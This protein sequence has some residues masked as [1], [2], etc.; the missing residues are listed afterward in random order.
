MSTQNAIVSGPKAKPE[1]SRRAANAGRISEIIID[2]LMTQEKIGDH[3]GV[4]QT[5]IA[6]MLVRGELTSCFEDKPRK[7]ERQRVTTTEAK[8]RVLNDLVYA[9]FVEDFEAVAALRQAIAMAD[10]E[11]TAKR[12][13]KEL[14]WRLDS[15]TTMFSALDAT[16][17]SRAAKELVLL[18][19]AEATLARRRS[20]WSNEKEMLR[21]SKAA[22][23]AC[24]E[25]FHQSDN[26]KLF[27][28]IVRA[29]FSA[30]IGI[31]QASAEWSVRKAEGGNV[32][33]RTFL[34]A[35]L[36]AYN[37]SRVALSQMADRKAFRAPQ[38]VALRACLEIAVYLSAPA[39]QHYLKLFEAHLMAAK[40][41]KTAVQWYLDNYVKDIE[42]TLQTSIA[43]RPGWDAL[44]NI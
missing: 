41:A 23:D 40:R 16:T 17:K 33:D 7:D 22:I 3:L 25:L 34:E 32:L 6:T 12:I 8:L 13:K 21:Q 5:H 44:R 43:G 37:D 27:S 26:S 31:N 14:S 1:E 36:K 39:E 29:P 28:P 18:K 35:Q 30:V 20:A 2:A 10:E 42:E 4:A 11:E 15:A 24:A 38:A 19:W 9:P